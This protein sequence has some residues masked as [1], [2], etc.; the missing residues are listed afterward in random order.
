LFASSWV[1]IHEHAV[2]L[3]L[4][5]LRLAELIGVQIAVVFAAAC[6]LIIFWFFFGVRDEVERGVALVGLERKVG[7]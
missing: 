3:V 1:E 6:F 5:L 2:Y 4:L 7:L